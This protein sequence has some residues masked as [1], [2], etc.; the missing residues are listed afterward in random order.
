MHIAGPMV[1][2][3]KLAGLG[4]GAKEWIIAPRT[5]FTFIKTD[6]RSFNMTFV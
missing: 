1:E 6:G 4:H 5:L 3:E 2:I